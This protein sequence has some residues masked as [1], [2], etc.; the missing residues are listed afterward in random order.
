MVAGVYNRFSQIKV[1][2]R[3]RYV[4]VPKVPQISSK[5]PSK[6]IIEVESDSREPRAL[7]LKLGRLFLPAR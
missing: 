3:T 2:A 6:K 1:K 4:P 7:A 5:I